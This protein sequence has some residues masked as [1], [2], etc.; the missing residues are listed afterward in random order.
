[1][2]EAE[3]STL[4][5]LQKAG[6]KLNFGI[7]NSGIARLYYT[8]G[9]GYYV[10]VGC[11]QLIIDGKIKVRQSPEGIKGFTPNALVL[12]DGTELEADVVVL[13]TGYDNMRT[14]VRKALGDGVANKLKD[15]WDLDEEGEL[16]AVSDRFAFPLL[17]I[18]SHKLTVDHQMWRPSGHPRFW[19]MGGNLALVRIYSKFLALQIKAVEEGYNTGQTGETNGAINGVEGH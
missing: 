13:A 15:V 3:R 17:D 6:F 5:G 10:D 2:A 9:G 19:Y 16:N 7:D 4:E 1:M 8:R 11:S 14:T 18:L 12:V